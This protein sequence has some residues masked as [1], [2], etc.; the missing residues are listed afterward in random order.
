MPLSLPAS[1][2]RP[3]SRIAGWHGTDAGR[4]LRVDQF[5]P[6]APSVPASISRHGFLTTNGL[7]GEAVYVA[8]YREVADRYERGAYVR[9]TV[10]V[11]EDGIEWFVLDN[12]TWHWSSGRPTDRPIAGI[13][14]NH[15]RRPGNHR[16]RGGAMGGT[17]LAVYD[18]SL[19]KVEAVQRYEQVFPLKPVDISL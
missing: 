11:P 5:D 16:P 3:S 18:P 10:D 19:V 2:R 4:G 6:P 12:G 15:G 7:F 13:I 14:D 17:Q 1:P 9:V 8:L